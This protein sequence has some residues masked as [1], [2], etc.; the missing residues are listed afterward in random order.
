MKMILATLTFLFWA[1]AHAAIEV[2]EMVPNRCWAKLGGGEFCLDDAKG[3]VRVL[4]H[5]AGWCVPCNEEMTA[6]SPAS[7][8]FKDAKVTFVSL[9]A[10]G[11][12]FGSLPT[13]EFLQEWKDKHQIPFTV[14]ASPKDAGKAYFEPPL[15]I[16]NVVIVGKD[17]NLFYKEFSP[18]MDVLFERIDAALAQ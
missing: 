6:L 13:M 11:F 3:S 17:G 8:K 4:V 9:S 7:K 16:P 5:N 10:A 2:G 12:E 1:Q 18:E 15:Y 14:A